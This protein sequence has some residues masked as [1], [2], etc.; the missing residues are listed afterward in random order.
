ML[1]PTS[2]PS[3]AKGD[4]HLVS[5]QRI[6]AQPSSVDVCV[7]AAVCSSMTVNSSRGVRGQADFVLNVLLHIHHV[8]IHG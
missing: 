1:L 6:S 7:C 5:K 2:S 8:L 3:H 4:S